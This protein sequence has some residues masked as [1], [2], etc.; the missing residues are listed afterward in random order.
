M[1]FQIDG[2][3]FAFPL[4]ACMAAISLA[5]AGCD[6]APSRPDSHDHDE[7]DADHGSESA[8]DHEDGEAHDLISLSPED[9]QALGIA[10]GAVSTGP[11]GGWIELP[12]EVRFDENRIALVS[13][14]VE[15]VIREVHAS[16]GDSVEAGDLLAIVDSR[17]L[18]E[19]KAAYL[20]ALASL[21]LVRP[22]FERERELFDR[23]VSTESRFQT[24]RRELEEA[25]IAVRSA[26][27]QLDA[28]GID[29]AARDTL[30]DPE[31]G[32]LS[33]YA[34]RAPMSGVITQ[35]HAVRGEFAEAGDVMP[36]FTIADASRVWVDAAIYG[37]DLMRVRPGARARIRL[38]ESEII[39]TEVSFVAPQI[40][41]ETRTG[42]ARLIV[43]NETSR[44]M[45][46]AFVT[47]ELE[48]GQAGR[49]LRAPASAVQ[50][51]NG[52]SVIFVP[53]D[54]GFEPRPVRLG[55]RGADFV[56]IVSGLQEGDPIVVT[57]A[58]A[59]KSELQ[60]GAFGD[61]HNH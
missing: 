37:P 48:D 4:A 56:E 13:A 53:E 59:L 31:T 50:T 54:D 40:G 18:A 44:L 26:E 58:F 45:P 61:G 12:G 39:E 19:A 34:L 14:P 22:E 60:K 15:G 46:G 32:A 29:E 38:S 17:E 2:G 30:A 52:E 28:L 42:L 6:D 25:R 1:T 51:L 23:G 27:F 11:V 20:S 57:G 5:L 49:L 36:T 35:R 41:A 7:T 55:R 43:D 8:H 16:M 33:R 10:L 9:R 21:E 47:V 3:R 24:A